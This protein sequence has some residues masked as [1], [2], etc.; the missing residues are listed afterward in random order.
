MFLSNLRSAWRQLTRTPVVSFVAVLSLALGIGAN[1][2]VF[3]LVNAILFNPMP[4]RDI[5][6]VVM[7]GTSEVRDGAP[8]FLS[9]TSRP[10]F[11]DLRDQ[12]SVFSGAV[13]T[14]FTPLSL[15][16]N[17]EPE[18][19]IGQ[20]VTGNYF[21]VLGPPLAAGRTFIPEED[22]DLGAHP[23]V[24][25]SHSFW[26]RRF[27]A[28]P[29]I[30]GKALTLN[31]HSFTVIGVAGEGFRGTFPV[32]GPDLWVPFAMYREA[33]TGFGADGYN[34]RRGLIYQAFGRLKDGVTLEQ[35]QANVD[36]IGRALAESFPTDNRGRSFALRTLTEAAFPPAFKQQL[37]LSGSLGMAVVALVLL[38]ACGNVANLQLARASTRRQEIAVRLSIGAS[39]RRL[40][41]QFLAES[42]LL[43]AAGGVGGLLVAYWSR[44]LLWAYRPPFMQPGAIDLSFDPRVL[45]FTMAVSLVTGL[46]FGLAPALQASRPDLVTELKERTTLTSGTRWYNIRHLLVV[47]QVALSLITLVAAGLFLRSLGN[48]QRIDVGF[49]GDRLIVLGMNAGTQGFNEARGRD[50]YRRT[51]ERLAGS[52]GVESVTLSSALPLFNGGF[53]RTT[54][55][56]DQD[57]KD[58]RNGRLTQIN[59]VADRYFETLGIPIMRGRAF[60]PNDRQGSTPVI[61]INEAMAKQFFPNEE[62]LGR[63]L[64]I[65]NRPPAREIVGIAKTIKY[66]SVG[67]EPTTHMYVPIEQTYA[68]Q[69]TVQVRAAGEPDAVL[70]T[71]RRELQQL[72]PTMPLLNVSTYRSILAT[73]LWAPRMGASLL[74]IFG[75]LALLLAAVGLYGVMAYSVTQRTREIGIR[76]ALG[77]EALQVRGMIVRQGLSLVVGGV[78]LGVAGAFGLSQLVTRLLFGITGAD[79]FTFTVVPVVLLAVAGIATAFPAWKASRVDPVDALRV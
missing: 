7:I 42:L 75:V 24:V 54:F 18:Q 11:I 37:V 35:A 3:T 55:R 12:Q 67:E 34:S 66:N 33:L 45:A 63:H 79:P 25:L 14:G 28:D 57:I 56:D 23:V 49:D 36:G 62:P 4:I 73:S 69:V 5:S 9:G 21:D 41:Q 1:T 29:G 38:I 17:G 65:F 43:A 77:A 70:G 39:R 15:S 27:G 19:L 48:A 10:N 30:I 68:S 16:G 59:E 2:T 13:L 50:L 51:L 26:T 52:P 71:V 78:L 6:R 53:S 32:G 46:L 47:G 64:H 58:P 31:G 22:R 74:T 40:I 61:I 76:M 72:E 20:M 60:T 44:A 8:Q